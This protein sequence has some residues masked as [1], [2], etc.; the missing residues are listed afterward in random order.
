MDIIDKKIINLLIENS[1]LSYQFIADKVFVSAAT[2]HL[3]VKKLKEKGLIKTP[4]YKP[5]Y[6]KCGYDVIA[7]VGIFLVK[8]DM[9]LDVIKD[10]QKIPEV[11]SCNYT[12]GNYS[13]LIKIICK[14]TNHLRDILHDKIQ[15]IK[16]INRTET[17]ISLEENINR[18]QRI[19]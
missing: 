19:E 10:L 8:S 6:S 2:V 17:M 7:F 13:L 14:D 5:D 9:Y 11:V 18:E 15:K 16:G 12:T 3:R 1:E 4:C